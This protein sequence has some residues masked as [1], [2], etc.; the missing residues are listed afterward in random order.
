MLA[1]PWPRALHIGDFGRF[2]IVGLGI[3]DFETKD[4]PGKRHNDTKCDFLKLTAVLP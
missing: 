4:L 3:D 1:K 2:V